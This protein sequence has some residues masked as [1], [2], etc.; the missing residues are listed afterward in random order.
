MHPADLINF[1]RVFR[2]ALDATRAKYPGS[3]RSHCSSISYSSKLLIGSMF[4]W[5]LS[6]FEACNASLGAPAKITLRQ[7]GKSGMFGVRVPHSALALRP[8]LDRSQRFRMPR[9]L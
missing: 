9:R 2:F 7:I 8:A 1:P 4:Q 6:L 3:H 5:A